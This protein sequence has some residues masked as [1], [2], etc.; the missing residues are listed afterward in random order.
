MLKTFGKM[1]HF[2]QLSLCSEEFAPFEIVRI[3]HMHSTTASV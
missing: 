2:Q 1:I 3:L